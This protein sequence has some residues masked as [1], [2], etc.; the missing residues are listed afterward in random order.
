MT[1][2]SAVTEELR[3]T[4]AAEEGSR[5]W[6]RRA[7]IA[8]SIAI[9]IAGGLVWRAKHKPPPP[10]KYTSAQLQVGDVIEKVQA[11]GAVQP[12][13][14]INVGAQVNGRV[15]AVL[16]DF[17][18]VVKKGD[19]LMEIDPS[20]YGT[21]VS[22]QQAQLIGQRAQLEQAK[23]QAQT[24]KAQ[25]ETQRANAETLRIAYDR[26]RRLFEQNLASKADLDTAKGQYEAMA[27]TYEASQ[28]QFAAATANVASAQAGIGAQAAQLNQMTTNLGYTKIYS[29]VDGK[30]VTRSI[31]PG[32]TV[33]ASFQA[34]VLFVIAQDLKK[35]RVLADVDE[36][37][38]GKLAEN[39]EADAVVDAFPGETFHG[40]VQQV[41]YSPNTV[42]G[43]VTYSAV[44]EVDNPE[45]KLRPGMTA[46]V[47]IKTHEV[48]GALRLPNA[49]LRYKPTPPM[50]P[51][52]KPVPQPP[53][54]PLAKGQG[55]VYILVNEKPGEEKAEQKTIAIGIT[56]G[57]NTEVSPG[58]LP[59]GVKVVTDETDSDDK[60]KKLF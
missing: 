34:P 1:D 2:T 42:Q 38:V 15:T 44:I 19:V 35:M 18:S 25:A 43:V 31:D 6:V 60:K 55:R 9:A 51:N 17:N 5:R 26:V 28:A 45:E 11:T 48:K 50:G 8:G 13:L 4:L 32:A 40:K 56:D 12:V 57:I 54:P 10:A 36:A 33:V 52:G 41:R 29:P 37:D 14:Q 47:T 7:A 59:Q 46:T 49:A 21:Q 27:A 30:V 16:V 23:A 39:M 24:A 3:R 58:A 53:E 20:I 22:A